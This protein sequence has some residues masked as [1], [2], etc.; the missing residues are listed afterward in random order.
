MGVHRLVGLGSV[1]RLQLVGE[2]RRACGN[3]SQPTQFVDLIP[4]TLGRIPNRE[5]RSD[6]GSVGEALRIRED[7][8]IN[9][10]VEGAPKIV[11]TIANTRLM[12]GSGAG[13]TATMSCRAASR[14]NWGLAVQW[15]RMWEWINRLVVSRC[16]SALTSVP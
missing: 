3:P 16:S 1:V 11:E 14:F 7:Q 13:I 4:V 8:L 15:C 10:V 5:H 6:V 9:Q 2:C 12:V